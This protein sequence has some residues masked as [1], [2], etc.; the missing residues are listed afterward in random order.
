M[1]DEHGD[2]AMTLSLKT[3]PQ[4]SGPLTQL[5]EPKP[6]LPIQIIE[7]VRD[8]DLSSQ[9]LLALA[10]AARDAAGDTSPRDLAEQLP[11]ASK[12]IEVASRAGE[13]WMEILAL[14]AAAIAIYVA[15]MDAR[16]AHR[17]ALQAI[18]QAHRDTDR[19]LQASREKRQTFSAGTTGGLSDEDIRKI[20]EQVEAHVTKDTTR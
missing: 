13:Q 15:H 18:D 16:E 2:V 19:A 9:E 8:A 3:C 7:A 20:A 11:R 4:C 12:I 10:D 17:D 1:L 6:P 14:V 5:R